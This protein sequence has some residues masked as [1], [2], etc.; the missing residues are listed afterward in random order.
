VYKRQVSI[1][2]IADVLENVEKVFLQPLN[3]RTPLLN[4]SFTQKDV[5]PATLEEY[6]LI[7]VSKANACFV[8]GK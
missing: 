3:M 6:R 4:A 8:R 1:R 2:R 5:D 7:I